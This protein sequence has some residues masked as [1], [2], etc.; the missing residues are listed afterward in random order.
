MK[1][2]LKI[3]TPRVG[4]PFEGMTGGDSRFFSI[5]PMDGKG[6]G[7]GSRRGWDSSGGVCPRP[8]RFKGELVGSESQERRWVNMNNLVWTIA[9]ILL[10]IVLLLI[11]L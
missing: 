10:I 7:E 6:Q 4:W 5:N 3:R 11:L 1:L 9:G 8:F 2:A